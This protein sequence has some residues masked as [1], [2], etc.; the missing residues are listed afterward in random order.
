MLRIAVAEDEIQC[1][2]ILLDHIRRFAGE[3]GI[4]CPVDV[5]SGGNEL[6]ERYK[7]QYDLV[8]MDVQMGGLDGLE[9]AAEIRRRDQG[10][11]IVFVTD[12]AQH[13]IR[14]YSVGAANFLLKP[15][16][17]HALSGELNKTAERVRRSRTRYLRVRTEQGFHRLE[18]SA[19]AHIETMGRRVLIHAGGREYLCRAAM[20][21]LE[22]QLA[23]EGFFRCHNAYLVNL[24]YVE[25]VEQTAVI[26]GGRS[27]LLS[28]Y[29]RKP[30]L[31][32]LAR[33]TGGKP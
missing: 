32:A 31:D 13:A 9:T 3:S 20:K 11:I 12:L 29:K 15:V 8:L 14:G 17:Y 28:R 33:H 24:A 30:F 1:R 10:V 25:S 5:Y 19:I 6:L 18:I 7:G 23:G 22:V 16:E 27:L 21:D 26:V 4:S 2:Q